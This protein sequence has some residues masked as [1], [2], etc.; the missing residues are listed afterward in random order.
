VPVVCGLILRTKVAGW[1][2]AAILLQVQGGHK[3]HWPLLRYT[4]YLPY[5]Y[6]VRVL[7][8]VAICCEDSSPPV[9]IIVILLCDA[10]ESVAA[11]NRVLR[12]PVVWSEEG[13]AERDRHDH[14]VQFRPVS[15]LRILENLQ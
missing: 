6:A 11:H 12:E 5:E 10:G 2:A 9:C 1:H 14:L 8:L 7:N 13:R 15:L 3:P 4:Q